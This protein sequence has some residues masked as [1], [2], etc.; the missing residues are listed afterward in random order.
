LPE[1]LSRPL[2]AFVRSFSAESPSL[3]NSRAAPEASA[4]SEA[5]A[6]YFKYAGRVDYQEH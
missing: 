5:S 4:E 6:S 1:T 2:V 3:P